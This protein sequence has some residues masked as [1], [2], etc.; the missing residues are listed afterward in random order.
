MSA[1]EKLK[2]NAEYYL[3]TSRGRRLDNHELE[4]GL[5]FLTKLQCRLCHRGNASSEDS[6]QIVRN[7]LFLYL[8]YDEKA[9]PLKH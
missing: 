2:R 8:F 1:K 3:K 9:E 4:T 6:E 5:Q 7:V